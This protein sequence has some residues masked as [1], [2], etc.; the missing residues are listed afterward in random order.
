[1]CVLRHSVVS[2]SWLPHG[3]KP[4]Q[5]YWSGLPRPLPEDLPSPG[6]KSRSLESPALAGRF[7][8]TSATW[9]ALQEETRLQKVSPW[10]TQL[11]VL[12]KVWQASVKEECEKI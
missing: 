2:V 1:M 6:I 7:L 3:Q 4:A 10:S 11:T 9:E 8:S 5:E 12:T